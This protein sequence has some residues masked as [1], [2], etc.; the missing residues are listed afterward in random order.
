MAPLSVDCVTQQAAAAL[1]K[2]RWRARARRYWSWR[3]VGS[4]A[5]WRSGRRGILSQRGDCLE[6]SAPRVWR[7]LFG[8]AGAAESVIGRLDKS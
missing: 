2:D 1:L 7:G 5:T 4:A 8:E 3:S 6:G